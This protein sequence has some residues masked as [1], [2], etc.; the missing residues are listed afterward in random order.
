MRSAILAK[1][2]NDMTYAVD[3]HNSLKTL[4]KYNNRKL[5]H[6]CKKQRYL[7]HKWITVCI[8]MLYVN[9]K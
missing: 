9:K 2:S 1:Q 8:R 4:W 5:T 3:V 6:T 7:Y